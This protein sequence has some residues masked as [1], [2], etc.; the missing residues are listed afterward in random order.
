[1]YSS[2][3]KCGCI[4]ELNRSAVIGVCVVH[5]GAMRGVASP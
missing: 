3:R 2:T 4:Q 5:I 1:M